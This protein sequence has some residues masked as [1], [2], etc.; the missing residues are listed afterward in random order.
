MPQFVL[1]LHES[2]WHPESLSPDELQGLMGRYRAW[3]EKMR[4]VGGSKLRDNEGRVLRRNGSGISVT[5]GPFAEAKE[6]LGGYMVVEA[7]N[8][9]EAVR[10]CQDSP[11]FE[12]GSI[13]IRQIET[14]R[15]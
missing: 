1:L 5:D 3:F 2:E 6:V 14:A 4:A 11:H 10:L 13:E 7:A 9:D 15:G 8:Y 12:L